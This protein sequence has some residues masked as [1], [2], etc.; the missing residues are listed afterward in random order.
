MSFEAGLGEM[1]IGSG[2]RSCDQVR[3]VVVVFF[4]KAEGPK[5]GL[6]CHWQESSHHSKER[7]VR[8]F[9]SCNVTLRNNVFF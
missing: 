7:T 5:M 2:I 3:A 6:E 4:Q 9:Y 8:T 1:G